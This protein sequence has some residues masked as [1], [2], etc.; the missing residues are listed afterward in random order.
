[1]ISRVRILLRQPR[2]SR[3]ACEP[4]NKS[5]IMSTSVSR[6]MEEH[7]LYASSVCTSKGDPTHHLNNS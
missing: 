7:G 1:M 3:A 2:S 4:K 6:D 5:E